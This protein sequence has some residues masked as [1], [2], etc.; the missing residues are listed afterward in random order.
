MKLYSQMVAPLEEGPELPMNLDRFR[1]NQPVAD[2]T[3]D[4]M[5]TDA[6]EAGAIVVIVPDGTGETNESRPVETSTPSQET[7]GLSQTLMLQQASSVDPEGEGTVTAPDEGEGALGNPLVIDTEAPGLSTEQE[8]QRAERSIEDE[9][10]E[11]SSGT[12]SS[13]S[14]SG[15]DDGSLSYDSEMDNP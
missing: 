6:M 4:P 12:E 9:Q 8:T 15:V 1:E 7:D 2:L 10:E 5:E 13:Y 3:P 11:S 14:G